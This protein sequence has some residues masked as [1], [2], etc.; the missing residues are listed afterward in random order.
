MNWLA[1]NWIWLAVA[2]GVIWVL[3]RTDRAHGHAG[4]GLLARLDGD[5]SHAGHSPA[6]QPWTAPEAAIDAVTG[7]A[8]G[9][10]QALSTVYQEKIYYFASKESR[11]R[12]EAAPQ[13]YASKVAGQPLRAAVPANEPRRRHGGCCG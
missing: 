12:F 9:V 6:P 10:A 8:V 7:E 13:E 4:A 11:E 2:I 5:H 3:M 1:Q